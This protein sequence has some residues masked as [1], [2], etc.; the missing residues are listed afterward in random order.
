M[1]E[2]DVAGLLLDECADGV[3][4]VFADHGVSLAMSGDGPV[5]DLWRSLRYIDHFGDGTG[6][7]TFSL[8]LAFGTS[9][10]QASCKLV[11]HLT[12]A[13]DIQ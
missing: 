13:L 11:A 4:A 12:A 2:L 1:E 9:R 5:F 8:G 10:P 6:G 3:L 7:A